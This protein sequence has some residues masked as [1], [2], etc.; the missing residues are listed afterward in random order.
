MQLKRDFCLNNNK[1]KRFD[2]TQN[3]L[4][5]SLAKYRTEIS[6]ASSRPSQMRRAFEGIIELT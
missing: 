2:F 3:R 5:S 4:V 6:R 1:E